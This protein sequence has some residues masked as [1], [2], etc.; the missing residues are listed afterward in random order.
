[1]EKFVVVPH[2]PNWKLIFSNE[3]EKV[4]SAFGS[5]VLSIHHIG[6]TAIGGIYAK[7]VIDM[8][9]VV[10]KL[11]ALEA[12]DK[13]MIELG[14]EVKGEFGISGRRYYRKDINGVRSF[15]LHAFE[16]ESPQIRRHLAFRD[17]LNNHATEAS[18][19]SELKRRLIL[20][21]DGDPEK[22]M[23]GKD[24]F[25]REIDRKASLMQIE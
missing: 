12:K 21:H 13:S 6:S 23:D 20:E 2:D 18:E 3:S 14:Y 10:T 4:K 11:D 22:Y 24:E 9:A 5:C 25:I 19:Y 8:L 17:Y 16:N 15:Q 1:M 7:P